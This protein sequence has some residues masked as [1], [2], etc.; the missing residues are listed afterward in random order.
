[1]KEQEKPMSSNDVLT[2][3]DW[4]PSSPSDLAKLLKVKL[5]KGELDLSPE[6]QCAA[7]LKHWIK[8]I[9]GGDQ[10]KKLT[11]ILE[12]NGYFLPQELL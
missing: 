9:S 6:D 7:I 10:V 3:A 4:W 2:I 8:I 5:T 12:S 1:V 11:D